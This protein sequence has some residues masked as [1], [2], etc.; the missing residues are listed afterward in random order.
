MNKPIAVLALATTLLAS[1][2]YAQ[3]NEP[4][5]TGPVILNLNGTSIPH[6]YQTYNT[7][8]TATSTTSNISFAFREDPAFL[9][10]DNVV[11]RLG[12]GPNL[13]VNGNFDAGPVNSQA[14]TGWTYLNTFGATFGGVVTAGCGTAGSNC[15][16][17][18]AVQAYDSITQ[19]ITT[20]P[21]LL[22]NIS[23]DLSD[24]STLT[25]FLAISNNGL[26]GTS[27][28]GVNLVVY[29]GEGEPVRAVPLPAA[30]PLFATGL[31]A[32]GLLGWRRKRKRAA[33]AT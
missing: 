33:V 16:F 30:L 17:D 32:L 4:P 28:N 5:P 13:L 29:A 31:G 6:S 27:G 3:N 20:T 8:F 14:P 11:V 21:G 15:Y 24:N 22:Y 12:A 19:A 26:P 7:S 1:N 9:S 18:G 25:T 10:L 23:F 2:A